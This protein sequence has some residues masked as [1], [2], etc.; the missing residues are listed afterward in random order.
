MALAEAMI[1]LRQGAMA[2]RPCSAVQEL[3]GSIPQPESMQ[4]ARDRV[5]GVLVQ[6]TGQRPF[7]AE[8][9]LAGIVNDGLTILTR[10]TPTLLG[11]AEL[12]AQQE[13]TLVE[14]AQAG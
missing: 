8:V 3:A 2:V 7:L 5:A 11:L 1:P 4:V 10:P 14:M 9:G 13:R 12:E 6:P